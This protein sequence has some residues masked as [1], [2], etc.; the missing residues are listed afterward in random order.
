M[1]TAMTTMIRHLSALLLL[2]LISV[3]PSHAAVC[4][5]QGGT[6]AWNNSN[7]ASWSCGHVPVVADTVIFDGTSG[8]GTVTVD[9]PNGAGVVTVSS[10]TC[11]AFTGTLDFSA[12]NNAV[13][14][15]T[16]TCSGTATRTLSLGDGTWTLG[17]GASWN[18]ATTTNLTFNANASTISFTGNTSS[19]RTF[20]SGNLT[21]ATINIATNTS[22]GIVNLGPSGVGYTIGTLTASAGS[23]IQFLAGGTTT[24]TNA[25]TLTGTSSAPIFLQANSFGLV[26]TISSGSAF[27]CTW[28][29]ISTLTFSGAG[30]GTATNS[31]DLGHNSGWTITPP[32]VGGG[33]II[34][35]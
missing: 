7:T 30:T 11:G 14:V 29:A 32:V 10:I 5:W 26:G 27:T 2:W 3:S 18:I 28:C 9:S 22:G 17:V 12:N 20:S 8:G 24:I 13:T 35:G 31:L 34:G 21:Y 4:T 25:A 33:H 16:F 15:T 23:V 19:T 1:G 6:A